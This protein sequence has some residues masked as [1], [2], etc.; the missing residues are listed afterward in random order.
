M[1]LVNI[2]QGIE[3]EYYENDIIELVIENAGAFSD[4][5]RM[6]IDQNNGG[7][8]DFQL[9]SNSKSISLVNYSDIIIDYFSFS[10]NSKKI[11]NKL[12]S[13]MESVA[14][15]MIE[16]KTSINAKLISVLDDIS[17]SLGSADLTYNL[18]FKWTDIFKIYNVSF[19]EEYSDISERI[20]AYIK[21][22]SM[23]TD[24]RLLFLVNLKAYISG[25]DLKN[26]Y[27]IANYCNINLFLIESHEFVERT[28]EK[29]YIIDKDLCFIDAN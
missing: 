16:E 13:N 1:K 7:E 9:S 5:I 12:Y 20:S 10:T 11:I 27:Q 24:V 19:E 14:N 29:R 26:I 23:F 25:N 4:I 22:L 28:C 2:K 6:L 8:G 15:N 18:D 17:L 21:I 3:I